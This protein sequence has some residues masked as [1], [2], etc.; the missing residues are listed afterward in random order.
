VVSKT[1]A[2]EPTLWVDVQVDSILVDQPE[3]RISAVGA[4]AD[5]VKSKPVKPT[6]LTT[7]V[8]PVPDLVVTK[9]ASGDKPRHAS[10]LVSFTGTS[11]FHQLTDAVCAK[12][13]P[14]SWESAGGHGRIVPHQA[15]TSLVVLQTPEIHD[16]LAAYL[17]QLRQR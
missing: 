17:D 14:T 9:E 11:S 2:G 7:R 1:E 3:P 4:H 6:N 12:I 10:S 8:Y 5:G 15:T 13:A 16:Q